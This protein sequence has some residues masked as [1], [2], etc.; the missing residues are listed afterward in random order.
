[1]VA[2]PPTIVQLLTQIALNNDQN[3]DSVTSE[4]VSAPKGLEYTVTE[5]TDFIDGVCHN[6]Q[7]RVIARERF[8]MKRI[9]V[10]RLNP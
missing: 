2:N 3:R 4:F 8:A 10:K 6:Y 1:M 5:D 9:Q 7:K